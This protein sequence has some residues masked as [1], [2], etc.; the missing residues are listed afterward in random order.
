MSA[1]KI[2]KS[3][4]ERATE[5]KPHLRKYADR[6]TAIDKDGNG[7]LDLTE[8]CEVLDE[9]ATIEKQ[10]RLLKWFGIISGLFSLLSIAAIV[11]LTYALVQNSKDTK[12]EGD[13]ALLFSKVTGTPVGIGRAMATGSFSDLLDMTPAELRSVETI[14]IPEGE[15]FEVYRVSSIAAIPN[16]SAKVTTTTGKIFE[17]ND[18]GLQAVNATS[19]SRR[20]LALSASGSVAGID[21]DIT[22]DLDP[23][24]AI[25]IVYDKPWYDFALLSGYEASERL[26]VS[27]KNTILEV[28]QKYYMPTSG[29]DLYWNEQKLDVAKTVKALGIKEGAVL[30]YREI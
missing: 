4:M 23:A 1:L 21:F 14:T 30:E 22:I 15:G 3:H 16:T 18:E 25:F 2:S 24:F 26:F 13:S 10:K 28:K 9:M 29:Y 12:F 27:S 11:G 8:V 17:I 20:L 6:L 5:F 7:E 19:G